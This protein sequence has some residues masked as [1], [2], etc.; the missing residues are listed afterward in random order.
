M[1]EVGLDRCDSVAEHYFYVGVD[2][3]KKE[4]RDTMEIGASSKFPSISSSPR[5]QRNVSCLSDKN[6]M[7]LSYQNA[8]SQFTLLETMR[9]LLLNSNCKRIT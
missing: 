7:T 1:N 3:Q 4:K 5:L 2:L 8:K 6:P 9:I